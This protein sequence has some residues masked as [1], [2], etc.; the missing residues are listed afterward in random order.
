MKTPL[1]LLRSL[2]AAALL[3]CVGF[4]QEG[5]TPVA[6]VQDPAPVHVE[7]GRSRWQR[8][9]PEERARVARLY[10]QYRGLPEADRE[11][12]R[13]QLERMAEVRREIEA[14]IPDELR[15]KL[16]RLAPEER[17]EVLREYVG[18]AIG[19]RAERLR[20]KLPPEVL[21]Q[22]EGATPAR[23]AE[24]LSDPRAPWREQA[25][26][27]ALAH[28]G[29]ELELAP[30]E[31]ERIRALPPEQK[32]AELFELGRRAMRRRGPPPGVAPEEFERW[33]KMPPGECLERLGKHGLGGPGAG[34]QGRGDPEH[35]G[36]FRARP[37]RGPGPDGLGGPGGPG[38]PPPPEG[39]HSGD[40]PEGFGPL[41]H[42]G[43]PG[44]R[45]G[46]DGPPPRK[47]GR[48]SQAA[49]DQVF[50]ALRPDK[51]WIVELAAETREYRAQEIGR[52]IRARVDEVLRAQ[53][54]LTA[55]ELTLLGT[56]EGRAYFEALR[57]IA[58]DPRHEWGGGR[59]RDRPRDG[60]GPPPGGTEPRKD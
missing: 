20:Q 57:D 6:P 45:R 38:G 30:E 53:P 29:R 17:R 19:E 60:G 28:L 24:L 21:S 46:E 59:R 18:S 10:E 33:L 36:E 23:R 39:R 48:I 37:G 41:D 42:R 14:R 54:G 31:L 49:Q 8:M 12:M 16:A 52:R 1:L 27:R 34:G 2:A 9:S 43:R 44:A 15:A 32:H 4:A 47:E 51:E 55:E 56:L 26:E 22:L 35:R 40:G 7:S 13:T 25:S 3:A 58:G 5:R 50:R 11:R